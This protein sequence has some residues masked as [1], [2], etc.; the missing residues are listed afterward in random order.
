MGDALGQ[1]QRRPA[2]RQTLLG[3]PELPVDLSADEA[4]ADAGVVAAVKQAVC[5]V[6]LGS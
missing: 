4:A 3:V 5:T 6:P 2:E 1:R